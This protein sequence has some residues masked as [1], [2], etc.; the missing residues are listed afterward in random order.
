MS[1]S[2][3]QHD[4]LL[5]APSAK[6]IFTRKQAGREFT[7]LAQHAVRTE[8]IRVFGFDGWEGRVVESEF[9]SQREVPKSK[10]EGT[11]WEVAWRVRYQLT[12]RWQVP[13]DPDEASLWSTWQEDAV[14]SATGPNL[15][16]VLDQALKSAASDAMKRCAMNLGSRFG[17][18]LYFP[19]PHDP[20]TSY[21][22]EVVRS[23]PQTPD[24]VATSA[25]AGMD[26]L[27]ESGGIED[28]GS[29]P[30]EATEGLAGDEPDKAEK[31]KKMRSK[32]KEIEDQTEGMF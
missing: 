13:A 32:I 15:P 21:R 4:Q 10:G 8:L 23:T 11:Q 18:G 6:A 17:I 5:R 27:P 28:G 31:I 16:D 24:A 12:V 26:D 7:Y 9:L 25:R 30:P 1:I 19:D 20:S 3:E 29:A 2:Q 14:G 22:G